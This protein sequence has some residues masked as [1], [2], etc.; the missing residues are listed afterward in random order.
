MKK[1]LLFA[2]FSL[3]LVACSSKYVDLPET[4]SAEDVNLTGTPMSDMDFIDCV[5]RVWPEK[6]LNQ[7]IKDK[8]WDN[9]NRISKMCRRFGEPPHYGS[10]VVCC[11]SLKK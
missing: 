5:D 7:E 11:E 8:Y 2:F 1:V 3:A 4:P 6:N 10:F 9:S